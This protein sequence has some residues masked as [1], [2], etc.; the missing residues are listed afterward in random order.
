MTMLN[1][2][3]EHKNKRSMGDCY[4]PCH[5]TCSSRCKLVAWFTTS[6]LIVIITA[7]VYERLMSFPYLLTLVLLGVL[8]ALLVGPNP[9]YLLSRA[10]Q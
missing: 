1:K 6:I 5:E 3:I 9:F 7:V 8:F 10:D 2:K 4:G